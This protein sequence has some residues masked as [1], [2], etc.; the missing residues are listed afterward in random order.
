MIMQKLD[1]LGLADPTL[2]VFT[3]D[4]GGESRVTSSAPLRAGKST[5]YEGGIRVPLIARY[6][7]LVPAGRICRTAV[8][9][10]DFYP[11]FCEA[12]GVEPE[13]GRSLDGVSMMP[14]LIDPEK[15]LKRN[16]LY[17][18][19]PLSKPH[20]LGGRSSGAVREG[21]WKLIEFFDSGESELYNLADDIGERNNLAATMPEKVVKLRKALTD[22]RDR[23]HAPLPPE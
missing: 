1:Q 5:L 19:Y 14:V 10:V 11:T 22:W 13:S 8:C 18:H 20:F 2:L 12:A 21:D 23:A 16:T 6:P 4:N 15:S 9:T 3:S 7:R 17:W